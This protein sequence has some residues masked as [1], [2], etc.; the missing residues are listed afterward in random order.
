MFDVAE[1]F[2]CDL[3]ARAHGQDACPPGENGGGG[4]AT[5]GVGI[6]VC[7][8]FSSQHGCTGHVSGESCW[9]GSVVGV[10][11]WCG[12]YLDGFAAITKSGHQNG[13]YVLTHRLVNERLRF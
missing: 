11:S 5:G 2:V 6:G 4:A 3:P 9:K 8:G 1:P 13:I 10:S 7:G 12:T